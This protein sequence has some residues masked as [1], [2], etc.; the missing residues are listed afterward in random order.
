MKKCVE[1][2]QEIEK[3]YKF[4]KSILLIKFLSKKKAWIVK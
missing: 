4:F 3:V 1:F 2:N